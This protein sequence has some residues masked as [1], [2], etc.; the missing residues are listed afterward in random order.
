M[1]SIEELQNSQEINVGDT[2][3]VKKLWKKGS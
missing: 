1:L 2:N 3:L